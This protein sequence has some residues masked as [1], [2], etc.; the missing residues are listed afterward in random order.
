[1]LFGGCK[2]IPEFTGFQIGC[3]VSENLI[4]QKSTLV[5]LT[6]PTNHQTLLP[7]FQLIET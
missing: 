3:K 6:D 1:M 7:Y 4:S 2:A 5:E